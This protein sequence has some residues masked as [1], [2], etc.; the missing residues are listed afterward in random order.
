ME[1]RKFTILGD[2]MPA[3]IPDSEATGKDKGEK[4]RDEDKGSKQQDSEKVSGK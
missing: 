3:S 4:A 2:A 1:N